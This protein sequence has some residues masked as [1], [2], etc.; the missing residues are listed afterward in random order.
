MGFK[1]RIAL[2]GRPGVGK[3]TLIERLLERL[4]VSAGGMLTKEIRVC[5]HRVGFAIVDVATRR[6]EVLAHIHQRV[7]PK[8]GA[9]TVNLKSLE[10]FGIPAILRAI[11][12]NDL[13][14]ID[15]VAPMEMSSPR[16]VPAVEAALASPKG[17][18]ISTHA[19]A[20]CPIAHRVRQELHLVR[21]RLGNRDELVDSILAALGV[22]D[23]PEPTPQERTGAHRGP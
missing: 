23:R 6:E 21:V 15:E 19:H 20:D 16:F 14:V 10:E 18:L 11:E 4:P 1:G 8:V 9:Y 3:T 22:Q 7:G 2:T 5:G 17:L 12:G 13:V